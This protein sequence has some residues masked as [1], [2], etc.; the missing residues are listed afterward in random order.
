MSTQLAGYFGVASGA[1][2]L[3]RSVAANSP[4][5][6]AGMRAG[7]VVVAANAKPVANTNDWVKAIKN[8]HGRPLTIVVMRDKKQQTL[9]L[10]PDS[11]KR[12]SLE[13]PAEGLAVA[14]LGRMQR[15]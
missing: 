9:T 10:T 11:K 15:A 8:S 3:V 4:A 13:A 5:A 6:L 12:S 2:L 7:D 1:G 14:G